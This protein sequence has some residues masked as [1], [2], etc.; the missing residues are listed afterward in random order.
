MLDAL[1]HISKI[2]INIKIF[3]INSL[4]YKLVLKI[5]V[6]AKIIIAVTQIVKIDRD[7]VSM[8]AAEKEVIM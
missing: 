8:S 2:S 5:F 6:L 1:K 3:V 7:V 4:G